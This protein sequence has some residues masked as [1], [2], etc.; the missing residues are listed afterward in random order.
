MTFKFQKSHQD[1]KVSHEHPKKTHRGNRDTVQYTAVF[2]LHSAERI[3]QRVSNKSLIQ[4][5]Q[6]KNTETMFDRDRLTLIQY[7]EQ[8]NYSIPSENYSL[9]NNTR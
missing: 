2:Y 5:L 7:D 4:L 9:F 1:E 6:V 8:N 3:I